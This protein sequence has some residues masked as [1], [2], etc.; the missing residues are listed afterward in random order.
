MHSREKEKIILEKPVNCTG[1]VENWLNSLLKMHCQSVG[2]YISQ[3]LQTLSDP[4]TDILALIDSSVLQVNYSYNLSKISMKIFH[5][6][7]LLY[8]HFFIGWSVSHSSHLDSSIRNSI[9]NC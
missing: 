7:V 1:G 2:A 5:Y 6:F 9:S 8:N 4:D 3:G